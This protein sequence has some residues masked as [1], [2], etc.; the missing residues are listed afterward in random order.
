M[1]RPDCATR[2]RIFS[3]QGHRKKLKPMIKINVG[4]QEKYLT[5]EEIYAMIL[6]KMRQIAVSR[7][8]IFV[9]LS[10]NDIYFY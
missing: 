3:I 5:P 2:Y 9:S 10:P 7:V 6:G 4:Q 8:F 1:Q